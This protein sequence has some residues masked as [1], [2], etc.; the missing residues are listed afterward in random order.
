MQQPITRRDVYSP[1]LSAVV[2]G[3]AVE[4]SAVSM[5]RELPD[6]L[7]G[8]ALSAASGT[9]RVVEGPDVTETVA[10]PWDPSAQWP[11]VPETP[12]AVS[13]DVGAGP[14]QMLGGG[15]VTSVQGGTGGREVQV[16]VAD[17]YQSLDRPISWN[18]LADAMPALTEAT[19][20]RY[21]S[22]HAA[23]V[24]DRILR[25]CGW[26]ATP[27]RIGYTVFS[28]PAM[29]TMWPEAGTCTASMRK[30]SP[31]FPVMFTEPWGKGV[32]DVTATYSRAAEYTVKQRGRV[33]MTAVA[34]RLNGGSMAL[35]AETST[36]RRFRIT[37][38]D[39]TVALWVTNS[40]G[41]WVSVL[42]RPRVL[43]SFIYATVEYVSDTSVRCILR[44][45]GSMVEATSAVHADLTT[46][47]LTSFTIDGDGV[48]AGFQVAF[49]ATS[50]TLAGWSR[51]AVIYD[52]A[53]SANALTVLPPVQGE[54][55]ADLLAQQC[56]AQNAT[57]WID[58]TGV[59]RWWDLARLEARATVATLTSD[60]DITDEG[61][62]WSHDLSSVKR[63]VTVDWRE[64]LAE[65]G[66]R[67]DV[68]L[69][70]GNGSTLSTTDSNNP[71][72]EWIN[73]PDDEVW[74][75]PD[76]SPGRVGDSYGDFNY[77][78]GTWY[79]AITDAGTTDTDHWAQLD[80]SLLW[81]IER[82]T[83]RLFKTVTTWTG[84][85]QATQRT[86][87]NESRVGTGLW[88]RRTDF[89]LPILRGKKKYTL[90]DQSTT[91][92]QTGPATAPDHVI[93]AGWWIQSA[94]QAQITADYAAARLTVPQ[95]VLSSIA[96]VPIPGLQLGDMVTVTDTAVTRLTIRGV[97]VSDSRSIDAGM[98][99][100]HA[101]AIRPVQVTRNG[102]TWAEWASVTGGTWKDWAT[103]EGGTWQQWGQNPLND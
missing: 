54:N 94:A 38:T 28:V 73:V 25:H 102:V 10:T 18:G 12:A 63:S 89:D 93:D 71:V 36:F 72:E 30:S 45:D 44:V 66:W 1:S 2:G 86:L 47:P 7:V 20:Q 22:L 46:L 75:M 61:F 6:P 29:G 13:A 50:G 98:G 77:G 35:V 84:S 4:V 70:Q 31:G 43:G 78:W 52:R 16:D 68:D 37:W 67:T 51:N 11:P 15:R 27:P 85:K 17:Q 33:E 41:A 55:C 64:P 9:I 65:G 21:V 91:A 53:S 56:A 24:T 14:V 69:W 19:D 49:P 79:G 81:S 82:V 97:V 3:H 60:D 58:E 101:V 34:G 80:G 23:A 5:D 83:D 40:A 92:A 59:L 90:G 57:Y 76:L 32:S 88:R 62:A 8:G 26:Y 100:R 48:G 42:T 103:A 99:M 87:D 39:T 74:L 95:P 96:L